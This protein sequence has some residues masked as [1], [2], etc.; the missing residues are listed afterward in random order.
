MKWF[1]LLLPL[2]EALAIIGPPRFATGILTLRLKVKIQN[3]TR[4][5][6]TLPTFV[7]ARKI[8]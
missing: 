6:A 2:W 1:E 4:N 5:N 8:G 3:M 7:T